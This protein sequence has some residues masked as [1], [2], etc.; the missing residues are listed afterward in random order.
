LFYDYE[1]FVMDIKKGL[2]LAGILG[3]TS[4]FAANAEGGQV[5]AA[6]QKGLGAVKDATQK[7][8]QGKETVEQGKEAAEKAKAATKKPATKTGKPAPVEADA[9][10]EQPVVKTKPKAV[11][12]VESDIRVIPGKIGDKDTAKEV[13]ADNPGAVSIFADTKMLKV[14]ADRTAGADLKVGVPAAGGRI[15]SLKNAGQGALGTIGIKIGG[16]GEDKRGADLTIEK[17]VLPLLKAGYDV[18]VTFTDKATADSLKDNLQIE[19]KNKQ[20]RIVNFDPKDPENEKFEGH[21]RAKAGNVYI[22]TNE[23]QFKTGPKDVVDLT[24]A[25]AESRS[26]RAINA[27]RSGNSARP[28][29]RPEGDAALNQNGVYKDGHVAQEVA[30]A[31]G[32]T[33]QVAVFRP[34]GPG[35]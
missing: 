3:I 20:I 9:E 34:K 31:D 6:I 15:D 14:L 25:T 33:Y 24:E 5:P 28:E 18:G 11:A 22:F 1:G 32:K 2:G 12:A 30:G 17:K 29:P 7:V 27:F 10:A 4:V 16:Y 35:M 21:L 13:A 26:G 8:G 19:V 23:S